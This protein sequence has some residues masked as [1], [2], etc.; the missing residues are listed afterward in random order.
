MSS[1]PEVD[2]GGSPRRTP[3]IMADGANGGGVPTWG[4]ASHDPSQFG[5]AFNG[6][7]GGVGH[8]ASWLRGGGASPV[9]PASMPGGAQGRPMQGSPWLQNLFSRTGDQYGG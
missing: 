4:G 6:G 2:S 1:S 9:N 3:P 5:H 8:V 7:Q